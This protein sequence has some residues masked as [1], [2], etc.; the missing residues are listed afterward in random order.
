MKHLEIH[1]MIEFVSFEEIN[2][3]TMKLV[4]YVNGH[5]RSCETCRKKIQAYQNIYDEMKRSLDEQEFYE[6][7]CKEI[8]EKEQRALDILPLQR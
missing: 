6:M 8:Y 5:I 3:E 1:E 2:E 4:Q 7:F